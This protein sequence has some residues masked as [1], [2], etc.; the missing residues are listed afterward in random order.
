MET[1]LHRELK[2]LYA[3]PQAAT[4]IRRGAFR[5]DALRGDELIE[6][7]YGPLHLLK[8]KLSALADE[9]RIRVV[10]PLVRTRRLVTRCPRTGRIL[11]ERRSP[12]HGALWDVFDELV[13]CTRVF[14][15]D[16]L[17]LEVVGVDV[18]ED[19]APPRGKRRRGRMLDVRLLNL[20]ERI[21]LR[22]GEDLWRLLAVDLPATFHTA[23]LAAALQ[24][25]RFVAQRI[26][27]C[28]REC[29]A[30]A[31]AGRYRRSRL[32]RRI[33]DANARAA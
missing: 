19:R 20:H 32:Y 16:H 2:R 1:S 5:V 30:V 9:H 3:G 29:G 8:R 25:K 4:E 17:T 12:S 18:A 14:P 21:E 7:Q 33:A 31:D 27:Y 24:V 6:I 23:D 22:T 10:K 15:H 28:L 26:A 13:F 11:R